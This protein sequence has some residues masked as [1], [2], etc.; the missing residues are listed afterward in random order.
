MTSSPCSNAVSSTSAADVE[1][2]R[3]ERLAVARVDELDARGGS[4][5]RGPRWTMSRTLERR[6]ELVAEG[7]PAVADPVDE[8]L[9]RR[10]GRAPRARR[11]TA[12]AP[13]PTCARGR[14]RGTPDRSPRR[15]ALPDQDPRERRIPGA[16]PLADRDDVRL[17]RQLVRGEPAPDAADPGHD[18]VEADQEPVLLAGVRRGPARSVRAGSSRAGPPALT[19]SQ[20]NAAISSGPC[21]LEQAVEL[22]EGG[23]PGRVGPPGRR[24]DVQVGGEVRACTAP[25]PPCVRSAR[26]SPS[27]TPW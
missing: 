3:Q 25:G 2:D 12:G 20:T 9:A 18:L 24:R 19:G 8:A 17:D 1:L 27:R 15:P 22:G 7:R 14:T 13:R 4:P 26:A 16:E 23:L 5:A 21:L 10:S 6:G 11:P